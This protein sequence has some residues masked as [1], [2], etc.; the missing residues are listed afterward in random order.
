M[1][2]LPQVDYGDEPRVQQQVVPL[3]AAAAIRPSPLG[4]APAV[5]SRAAGCGRSVCG[6]RSVREG[7]AHRNQ[8]ANDQPQSRSTPWTRRGLTSAFWR[9]RAA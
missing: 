6:K 1:K 7:D 9:W 8:R 4:P 3:S 2:D 5:P